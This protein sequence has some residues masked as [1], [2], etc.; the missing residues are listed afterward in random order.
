MYRR[1]ASTV[2]LAALSLLFV[3]AAH[4]QLDPNFGTAGVVTTNIHADDS[5]IGTF[6]LPDGKIFVV[7][8]SFQT[9]VRYSFLRYNSDGTP[10]M[11]YGTGGRVQLSGIFS[12]ESIVARHGINR[13][14]RQ[15]DGKILLVGSDEMDGLVARLNE[16]GSLDNS[17]AVGG[18]TRPNITQGDNRF[19]IVESAAITSDGKITVAGTT[20]TLAGVTR[21]FLIRYDSNGV[22]DPSLAGQGYVVHSFFQDPRAVFVQPS[23]KIVVSSA[24]SRSP[25]S[26]GAIRRFNVDGSADGTFASILFGSTLRSSAMQPDG[27]ILVGEVISRNDALERLNTDVQISRYGVDGALDTGF[28]DAGRRLID[29]TTSFCD[30]SPNAIA[31]EPDGDIIVSVITNVQPNRSS[32]RGAMLALAKLS[33]SGA[34]T[35]KFLETNSLFFG[36]AQLALYADGRILTTFRTTNGSDVNLLLTRATDVS[37]QN[38]KFRGVAFDLALVTENGS[39]DVAIFRPSDR[40]WWVYPTGTGFPP[41]GLATDIPVVADYI[42]SMG[43]EIAVFRPSDGT[44]YIAR[45]LSPGD[46]ITIQW[47]ANGDIPTPADFDGDGKTDVAVFRPSEGVWY[48]RNSSDGGYRILQWGL[49]GDKPVAGDYDGDGIDDI[50]IFRPSTGVWYVLKSSDGQPLIG[51]FGTS[52]DVPVPADYDGDGK[53]DI[54]VWRPSTGVWYWIKSSDGNAVSFAWGTSTDTAVPADYN[55]DGKVDVAVFRP[56]EGRWYVYKNG[57]GTFDI[58]SWGLPTDVPI[59][60]RY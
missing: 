12:S 28:G 55:G 9:V 46:F 31:V 52:G 47:G 27:R 43:S 23:G 4:A 11:T 33:S 10:D 16:D 5:S 1:K 36:D 34:I 30:D 7:A 2:V 3:S 13:A 49:N 50:G 41:F 56:S 32:F 21:L 8:E 51:P 26:E 15:A 37:L 53:T 18:V 40:R 38:Y 20:D 59:S 48:L 39:A 25:G 24:N 14:Y 6:I 60:A 57:V 17:F 45:T 29:L 58:Y 42:G 22:L 19:D 35:G 54:A 44:W